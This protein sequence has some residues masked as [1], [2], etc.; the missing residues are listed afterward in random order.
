MSYEIGWTRLLSTQLGSSTYAFTLMLGTFL[1]GIVL[2]SALF[3]RWSRRRVPGS[4]TFAVTQTLTALAALAFLVFFTRLIE[5]LP[6]ILRATHESFRGL[7]LAQF[8]TSALAMLPTAVVFG[9]NFPAVV[10]LIAGPRSANG[11]GAGAAVGR[12]YAWNT[13][14]AI[15]GAI[16][17]G[18][19]LMPRL[20]SFHLL[21]ATAGVNLA[22]AAAI[23]FASAQRLPWKILAVAGN[24]LLHR[25][26]LPSS[27]SRIIFTIPRWL[28]STP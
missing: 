4:M 21:A 16:A 17:A 19:W 8:V 11:T 22:L 13:L 26:S 20:G 27:A 14:G 2:G 25:C 6:P 5:V 7:V 9:F 15:V 28:R 1:T 3:E 18:F 10:V 12:A 24:L 23:S